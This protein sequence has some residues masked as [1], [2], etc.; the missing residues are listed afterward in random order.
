MA[1][2]NYFAHSENESGEFHNLKD[3]LIST[4]EKAK[5]FADKWNAGEIAY[6]AG[7]TH[8]LGKFNDQFQDYLLGEGNSVEHS[9]SGAYYLAK[10]YQKIGPIMAIMIAGH[11]A[12]LHN[13][14]DLKSK[15]NFM[16]TKDFIQESIDN[17][18]KYLDKPDLNFN[19]LNIDFND[20]L[21]V[22]FFIRMIFSA[23][24]DADYLDT[25]DHFDINRLLLREQNSKNIE[26]LWSNFKNN[27]AYLINNSE[28]IYVNRIRREIYKTIISNADR[29]N[30]F[31]SMTVPT[32]GGKTR[33][34]LGFALKHAIYNNME[35]VIVV[36]PYTNIIEQTA[37]K[38]RDILGED[39]VLEHHSNFNYESDTEKESKIKLATEN[40]DMPVIVTTSVQFFESI[41]ASRTSKA[42]K[43]HNIANSIIIFDEVQTLPPGYLSSIMQIMKQ[44]VKNY[45]SSIV[46]STATQPAF[47][48]RDGF[49]GIQDIKELAPE[50]EKTYQKL[51]RVKYNFAYLNKKMSW[52]EVADK[53][54]EKSQALAVVNTRDDARE[55]FSILKKRNRNNIFH[56]S[57]YM[58]A[59]HRKKVLA[60]VK[61][62][63]SNNESCYLVSTQLIEAGVDID[64]PLV[65]RAISPLDS[66]VQAAGRCNREGSLETGEVIIFAPKDLKLP[67]GVYKTATGITKLFLDDPDNLQKPDIFFN[68]FNRLYSDVNLDKN[69]IQELRKG[70]NYRKV[71]SEFKLI[72]DDTV[73]VI[74]ESNDLVDDLPVNINGIKKKEFISREEWRKLQPYLVSIRKYKINDLRKEGLISELIEDVY[75]W[76]GN[77]DED[78][79]IKKEFTFNDLIIRGGGGN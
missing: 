76:I 31:F 23:V 21:E 58:C 30:D 20:P 60:E 36:I 27:Q 52:S 10:N 26:D 69:D 64:F 39:C 14:A 12:G 79:G 29:D 61:E 1:K 65:L 67:K 4:A 3:H 77:Y 28:D 72:P 5:S 19:N 43:L 75:I 49:N 46:F 66:I 35:R 44:L 2:N 38:Y 54:L 56:L 34:G 63:L 53:M 22:E 62:K 7:L 78:E 73:N 55:L 18:N 6:I 59:A 40:W 16:Q 13:L 50:P 48:N 15:L 68:Y 32:G 37:K 45:N 11:H 9:I 41:F 74:I 42:R 25:E 51:N 33:S 8:D 70:L 57:T 71:A 17:F 47:K 24:V